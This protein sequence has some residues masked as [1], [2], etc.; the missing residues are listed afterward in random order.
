MLQGAGT[1]ADLDGH[2]EYLLDATWTLGIEQVRRPSVAEGFQV[3]PGPEPKFGYVQD[4][5]WLRIPVLNASTTAAWKINLRVNFLHLVEIYVAH[6]DGAVERVLSL[7]RHSPFAARPVQYHHLVADLGIAP[8]ATAD[9]YVRYWTEGH[10][11]LPLVFTSNAAFEARASSSAAKAFFFQGITLLLALAGAA[12]FVATRSLPSLLYAL[13][14]L[15]CTLFVLH[16]DGYAFRYL[17]PSAPGLNGFATVPIGAFMVISGSLFVRSFLRTRQRHRVFDVLL[18]LNVAAALALVA[19][20]VVVDAQQLKKAMV[21]LASAS[22]VLFCVAGINAARRHFREVRFFVLGWLGAIVAAALISGRQLIGGD[23][24][25]ELTL[26]AM[27]YFLVWDALMMG[28]AL[29]DR[30]LQLRAE[31]RRLLEANLAA[32]ERNLDMQARLTQLEERYALADEMAKVQ[33]MRLADATHDLRAP[34][35]ALHLS[36][37][38]IVRA[39]NVD[40]S[41]ARS[42]NRSFEYLERLVETYLADATAGGLRHVASPGPLAPGA[43][44]EAMPAQLVMR[45]I[46]EMFADEARDKG[47][48]LT[49]VPSSASVLVE[50]LTLM[51]ILSN[52]LSNA[53]KYTAEG[54]ILLGCRRRCGYLSIEVHDTGLGMSQAE[55]AAFMQRSV[56]GGHEPGGSGLGLAIVADL[57]RG[58]GLTLRC[59]S[60][61]GRGTRFALE[62][63]LAACQT[64][65]RGVRPA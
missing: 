19:A 63:P 24:S 37:R 57:A 22:C 56:R 35:N 61:P 30:Y 58:A 39:G 10:S 33:G 2:V 62:V 18:W 32:A 12:T 48:R 7:D 13:F 52:L 50:P 53:I 60:H 47:L 51:R 45:N 59:A 42:I 14:L 41:M 34:L 54:R 28:L 6:P 38:Q 26:D 49:C 4:V 20:A 3:F 46:H 55:V 31:Q 64:P 16:R 5:V 44:P 25:R 23:I 36:V 15:G 29:L 27:R 17:W 8:G 65:A 40:P 9:V 43:A 11:G 21:L 1:I